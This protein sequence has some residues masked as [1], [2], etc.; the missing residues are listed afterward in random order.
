MEN[1]STKKKMMSM[2]IKT[3]Y[4]NA[5][6]NKAHTPAFYGSDNNGIGDIRGSTEILDFFKKLAL[7]GIWLLSVLPT[8]S[9]NCYFDIIGS[10]CIQTRHTFVLHELIKHRNK[11]PIKVLIGVVLQLTSTPPIIQET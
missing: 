2:T 11:I 7:N 6:F 1:R 8:L 10:S 4:K 3:S 5:F 9:N